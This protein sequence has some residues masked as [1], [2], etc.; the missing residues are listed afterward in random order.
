MQSILRHPNIAI[1]MAVIPKIP[2]I[3][4]VFENV[5]QG[6]M[7]DLLH[8]KKNQV[9]I[10]LKQRLRI[11]RDSAIVFEYMHNL[12]IVHRDIKSHNILVDDNFTV[13]VCDFGLAKFTAD[14]NRGSMQYAGTPT[15]MA[16]ELFQKRAYDQSVDVYAFGCLLW[17]I[18]N[19]EVPFDGLDAQDISQKVIKGE[20][21]KE[22][23]LQSV[24]MRLADLVDSCRAVD[25]TR[26]PS[27]TVI[28]EVLND[29]Y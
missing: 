18:I 16:P 19:R 10:S 21:L 8:M 14:L 20:K 1:L 6:S 5:S 25:Q 11:A 15:Y 9:E 2:D 17:E 23:N 4:I 12:G 24:D 26:R 3:Y 13:K 7:F 27:F 29:I 22:H 28:A